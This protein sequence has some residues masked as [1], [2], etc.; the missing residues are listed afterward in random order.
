MGPKELKSLLLPHSTLKGLL[1]AAGALVPDMAA[2][3]PTH[4]WEMAGMGS[5]AS[6]L[7][8]LRIPFPHL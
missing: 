2:C 3:S 8:Q 6:G 5:T 4:T 7:K 1:S